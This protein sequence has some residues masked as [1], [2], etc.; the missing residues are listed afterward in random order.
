MAQEPFHVFFAGIRRLTDKRPCGQRDSIKGSRDAH[1]SEGAGDAELVDSFP[2]RGHSGLL[3]LFGAGTIRLPHGGHF[4]F[5]RSGYR[6]RAAQEKCAACTFAGQ[7]PD[8]DLRSLQLESTRPCVKEVTKRAGKK[9]GPSFTCRSSADLLRRFR[10]GRRPS[11][12]GCTYFPCTTGRT[13]R[14][15]PPDISVGGWRPCTSGAPCTRHP[16][17][18]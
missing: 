15:T 3:L 13:R 7:L 18:Y 11:R 5:V 12:S 10:P 17:R 6:R 9:A 8:P 1:G 16:G 2:A 14:R 4:R